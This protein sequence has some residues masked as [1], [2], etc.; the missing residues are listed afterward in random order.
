MQQYLI[1]D[2]AG[3]TITLQTVLNG[4]GVFMT[5]SAVSSSGQSRIVWSNAGPAGT[6]SIV[7]RY[8]GDDKYLPVVD[9]SSYFEVSKLEPDFRIVDQ[10]AHEGSTEVLVVVAPEDLTGTLTCQL[11]SGSASPAFVA[12]QSIV[13]SVP[14]YF[15]WSN[16]GPAGIYSGFVGYSGDGKYLPTTSSIDSVEILPQQREEFLMSISAEDTVTNESVEVTVTGPEEDNLEPLS[17]SLDGDLVTDELYLTDGKGSIIIAPGDQ[18]QDYWTTGSHWITASYPGDS[19]YLPATS[20]YEFNVSRASLT[21]SVSTN[22]RN[23]KAT[24]N[25]T[26]PPDYSGSFFVDFDNIG[27]TAP[28]INGKAKCNVTVSAAGTYNWSVWALGNDV[29]N[30][31]D[32]RYGTITITA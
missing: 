28:V 13:P 4:V 9:S 20:D 2:L 5:S 21:F 30:D 23:L 17:I 24:F 11:S 12:T 32:V 25:I 8:Q 27:Y 19:K 16:A 6:Y 10:G 22:G 26:C 1:I 18:G 31:S 7:L 29:Y 14:T 15:T 3:P